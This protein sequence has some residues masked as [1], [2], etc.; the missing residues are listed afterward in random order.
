MPLKWDVDASSAD[1]PS[2][3]EAGWSEEA[4]LHRARKNADGT[5]TAEVR[6]IVYD[7]DGESWTAVRTMRLER[8]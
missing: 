2:G 5:M 1:I 6:V 3:A 4:V 8:N 7:A